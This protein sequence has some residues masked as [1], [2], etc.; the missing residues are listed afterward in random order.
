MRFVG[1]SNSLLSSSLAALVV[2][3]P[4]LAPGAGPVTCPDGKRCHILTTCW[5]D[6]CSKEYPGGTWTIEDDVC[7]VSTRPQGATEARDSGTS[8]T[9]RKRLLRVLVRQRRRVGG[10]PVL[11][12]GRSRV[13][14][15]GPPYEAWR[16]GLSRSGATARG[17]GIPVSVKEEAT[18]LGDKWLLVVSDRG[19]GWMNARF[20]RRE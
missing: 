20:V 19:E 15:R 4:L 12:P 17:E 2:A 18:L 10:E 6:A 3:I 14:D 16:A 11:P 1:R 7:P 8:S 9:A 5:C 13:H